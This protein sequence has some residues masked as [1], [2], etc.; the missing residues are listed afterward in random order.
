MVSL[1]GERILTWFPVTFFFF[2]SNACHHKNYL[3]Y[4]AEELTRVQYVARGHFKIFDFILFISIFLI[5]SLSPDPPSPPLKKKNQRNETHLHQDSFGYKMSRGKYSNRNQ[6]SKLCNR[7]RS[8]SFQRAI[9]VIVET[10]RFSYWHLGSIWEG[11]QNK[12]WVPLAFPIGSPKC[13]WYWGLGA[14]SHLEGRGG[15]GECRFR[16]WVALDFRELIL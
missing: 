1:K 11:K 12:H 3:Q 14:P 15:A 7:K 13:D 4:W 10:V 5:S 9:I 6:N 2:W 16:V 8:P